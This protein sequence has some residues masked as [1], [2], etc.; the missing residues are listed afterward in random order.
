M[1]GRLG[2]AEPTAAEGYELDAIA[3]SAIGGASL[4]GGKGSVIGTVLGALILAVLKNGMTLLNVQSY[5][6][7]I[8]TGIVII[9]AVMLDH[10]T[11]GTTKKITDAYNRER[12]NGYE[13]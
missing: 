13:L 12:N 5:Y 10:F 11:N 3:A 2:A 1:V 7:Q 8:A 6:Q 9:A 4:A